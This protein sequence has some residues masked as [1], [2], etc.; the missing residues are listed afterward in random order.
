MCY[1]GKEMELFLKINSAINNFVW[2]P[3]MI[4]LLMGTG[5]YYTLRSRGLQFRRFGYIMKEKLGSLFTGG[6]GKQIADGAVS[7]FQALTTALAGTIGTGN[8]VGVATAITAGGPGAI[9]WMWVSA[10]VGMM[11]KYAEIVLS[12]NYRQRN[13]QNEWKG[14]PMYYIEKGLKQKWLAVV[15]AIFAFCSTFGTGNLTQINAIATSMKT[16]F[17]IPQLATGIVVALLIGVVIIGG[18]KRIGRI[19][20]RFVPLMSLFYIV[21]AVIVLFVNRAAIFPSFALIFRSAFTPTAAFGGFLG[22]GVMQAIR[23]GMAR[24]IFSNEAGLGTAP[25]AHAAADTEHPVDQGLW[26]VFEVFM[27][28]ILVCTCTALIILTSGLWST[29]VDGANL[30]MAAFAQALP[31][32]GNLIITIALFFFALSTMLGWSYYGEKCFEY[33][34]GEKLVGLYR[35]AFIIITVIGSVTELKIVWAVSDTFN[36]LMA[37][38]N[39]IALLGLSGV[40]MKL[41]REHFGDKL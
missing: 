35:V 23:M 16:T 3:V 17:Q 8:I 19:T 32:V 25:I 37:I 10:L 6:A 15:F 24:G 4:V 1:G 14:G 26:G 39:L 29:G 40:V 9:F 12:V 28:T 41:T 33:L 13:S 21:G 2:G 7:P 31:H 34:F 30:T 11:T 18:I 36:G 27:D 22:A 5:L 20:E 38:P